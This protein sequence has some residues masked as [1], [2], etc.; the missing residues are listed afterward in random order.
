MAISWGVFG[1]TINSGP[2][3]ENGLQTTAVKLGRIFMYAAF[4][5][6][7]L[8]SLTTVYDIARFADMTATT[9]LRAF[10]RYVERM[11]PSKHRASWQR[12][13]TARQKLSET[14][15]VQDKSQIRHFSQ[16]VAGCE[17]RGCRKRLECNTDGMRNASIMHTQQ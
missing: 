2:V 5:F 13:T 4:H 17:V 14:P 6:S 8:V 9:F 15:R 12:Y 11:P 16:V 3:P 1:A 10:L 7:L